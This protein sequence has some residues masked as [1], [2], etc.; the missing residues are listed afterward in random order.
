MKIK[1]L[2]IKKALLLS[3]AALFF[4]SSCDSGET[5]WSKT[6]AGSA[7]FR[8]GALAMTSDSQNNV[9]V[10][11][12]EKLEKDD[13]YTSLKGA[14]TIK[15]NAAG[16]QQW[17]A[18]FSREFSSGINSVDKGTA[19]S[20]DAEGN[21]YVMG[22]SLGESLTNDSRE[23]DFLIIKYD[24]S[25]NMLWNKIYDGPSNKTDTPMGFVVDSNGS[26]YVT[27]T[28]AWESYRTRAV[29][30]AYDTDG[31]E[32]WRDGENLGGDYAYAYKI[33]LDSAEN[34][35]VAASEFKDNGPGY[36]ADKYVS[37]LKYSGDGT[38]TRLNRLENDDIRSKSIHNISGMVLDS[39]DNIYLTGFT[40]IAHD[41]NNWADT[42]AV[43]I[44]FSSHGSFQWGTVYNSSKNY[45]DKGIDITVAA[46]GNVYV[47]AE[48]EHGG[49]EIAV[50]IKY[51]QN[52]NKA[53][54]KTVGSAFY[55]FD[56][57]VSI[58]VDSQNRVFTTMNSTK[59][60][61]IPYFTI[62]FHA[63]TSVKCKTVVY[64]AGGSKIFTDEE[65]LVAANAALLDPDSGFFY[66]AGSK[67]SSAG[68]SDGKDM[69]TIKKSL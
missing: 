16:E 44:K 52:G 1:N 66:L 51:D 27:G 26:V 14:V 30:I 18:Q 64:D 3:I 24:S 47:A 25:G 45:D 35:I 43:T 50:T 68:T 17:V 40:Y 69:I 20:V 42:D 31:N 53:W 2:S 8:D 5:I 65:N 22:I 60:I 13:I 67:L 38:K 6:Y 39:S 57:P 46:D 36:S 11:G 9:Y 28:S 58:H 59:Y 61:I 34:I 15:Y 23:D 54:S 33:A 10:T 7:G 41:G 62:G 63:Y 32:L 21:V 48:T 55:C 19:I 49:D 56:K 4:M 29:T 37:I 12:Y